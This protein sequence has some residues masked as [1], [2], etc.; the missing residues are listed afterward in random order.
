M[1]EIEI[2]ITGTTPLLHHKMPQEDLYKLLGAKTEKKKSEEELTPREIAQRH[3][4]VDSVGAYVI[5]VEML[6]G[7]IKHIASDYK[8][9]N[10]TR[11]SLKTVIAGAI[12]PTHDDA[13]ILDESGAAVDSFEVDIRRG[14]NHQKGA[15]AICRP[16]FDRWKSKFKIEID[17]SIVPVKT[18]HEMIQDAGKRAGLGSYRVSRGGYYGQFRVTQWKEL[19]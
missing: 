13:Y 15:V 5:P 19:N 14:V 2:E 6:M 8:Q 11:R 1:K 12:R 18:A 17:E 16:R 3:T 4:Y 9:K 7:A 10:T